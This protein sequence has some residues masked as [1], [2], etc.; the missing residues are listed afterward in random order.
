MNKNELM[1]KVL[2]EYTNL[3][4]IQKDK[5]SRIVNRLLAVNYLCGGRKRDRDDY[6]FIQSNEPVSY[7]HLT[8]PTT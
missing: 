8:L 4:D 6:F 5:F 3:S 2:Q 1:N 7:T